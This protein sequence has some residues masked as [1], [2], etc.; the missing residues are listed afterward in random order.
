MIDILA[1]LLQA[2]Y[3][4]HVGT[5]NIYIVWDFIMPNLYQEEIQHIRTHTLDFEEAFSRLEDGAQLDVTLDDSAEYVLIFDY[6]M[7]PA[8]ITKCFRIGWNESVGF[9]I[10][11][12]ASKYFS[13]VRNYS[14][15]CVRKGNDWSFN[16]FFS[17][18]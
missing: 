1:I 3:S 5:R 11:R 12:T 9:Y 14:N 2:L 13:P 15:V 7:M 6:Y 18:G 17:G 4:L 10:S 16:H 8:I